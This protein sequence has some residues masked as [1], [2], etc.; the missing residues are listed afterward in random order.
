MDWLM[1]R[2]K[3]LLMIQKKEAVGADQCVLDSDDP[4]HVSNLP[5]F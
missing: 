5:D 4:I 1:K 2:L 3:S